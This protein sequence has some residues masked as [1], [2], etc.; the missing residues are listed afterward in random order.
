MTTIRRITHRLSRQV[1]NA[2]LVIAL[3]NSWALAGESKL[4]LSGSQE[5]PP[6][7]TAANGSGS[8][9]I[10]DNKSVSGSITT[11]G[12]SGSMAHIHLG[13]AGK[14]GPVAVPL[15]KSGDNA[16]S[17]P[18]AASLSDEQ[19]AAYKAGELYVNVHSIAH[20]G[21]EIRGQIKP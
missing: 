20:P 11:T 5:V 9:T 15:I 7:A 3:G 12:M 16:W 18:A 2:F 19:Y 10:N 6:V 8:I 17:V 14:N 13:A 4:S 1:T 21:G